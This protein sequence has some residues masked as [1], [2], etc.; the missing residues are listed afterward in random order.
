LDDKDCAFKFP[1]EQGQFSLFH[2]VFTCSAEF[3]SFLQILN[4]RVHVTGFSS[5][6]F[7]AAVSDL[8]IDAISAR[9]PELEIHSE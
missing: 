5:N 2:D 1:H 7:D 6:N 8:D 9:L 4:E 3:S